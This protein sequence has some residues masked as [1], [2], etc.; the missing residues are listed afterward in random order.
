MTPNGR[1]HACASRHLFRSG[2][3]VESG[4]LGSN[5]A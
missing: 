4:V 1:G 5:G 3:L 2:G